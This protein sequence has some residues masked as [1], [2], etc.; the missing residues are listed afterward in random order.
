LA[1]PRR[2]PSANFLAMNLMAGVATR[3]PNHPVCGART[4]GGG[5]CRAPKVAGGNRCRHHGG[6]RILLRRARQTL[7]VTRSR[8]VASKC[9]WYLGKSIRNRSRQYVKVG[10]AEFARREA[11]ADRA[12]R[13]ITRAEREGVVTTDLIRQLY[14]LGN[15]LRPYREHDIHCAAGAYCSA[16]MAGT[17]SLARFEAFA[18][19]LHLDWEERRAVAPML[20][21]RLIAKPECTD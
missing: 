3:F 1:A 14:R 9:L 16:V 15:K 19:E 4:K 5:K 12:S 17:S 18:S 10:D 7:A 13:I 21:T 11:D 6:G 8:S 2:M 20:G